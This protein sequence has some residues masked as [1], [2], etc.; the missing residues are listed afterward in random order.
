MM[1]RRLRAYWV[2]P[3]FATSFFLLGLSFVISRARTPYDGARLEPGQQAWLPDGLL[4]N[5]LMVATGGLQS[6]D[7]ITA[8]EGKP[9]VDWAQSLVQFDFPHITPAF[10]QVITYSVLRNGQAIEVQATQTTY[11][12]SALLSQNWGIYIVVFSLQLIM[13]FVLIRRPEE[14]AARALF[15]FAWSMW[16]FPAWTMGLQVTDVLNGWGYWHYRAVTNLL[17]LLTFSALLHTSLVFPRR[18]PI[19]DRYPRIIPVI[20]LAPYGLFTIYMAVARLFSSNLWLWLG[21]WNSGEWAVAMLYLL[22]FFVMTGINY[23]NIHEE[24]TRLKIRWVV[25]GWSITAAGLI[26]LWLLPGAILGQPLI[27]AG[28]ITLLALPL[29]LAL[30]IA[31]LRHRLFDINIVINRTLVYG[32]LTIST[33]ALYI[34]TVG[35]L[36]NLVHLHDRPIIAFLTTGLVAV[37]FQPMHERL[38]LLVNRMMY[39]NRDD[40]Y[41][42]LTRLGQKLEATASVETA[43]PTIVETIAQALKLPYVAIEFKDGNGSRVAAAYGTA[44]PGEAKK[45]PLV[46]QNETFGDLVLAR[47]SERESFT[48]NEERLLADLA[49]EVEVAAHNVRLTADLQRSRQDLVTGREEERRRIRRDLHDEIG[50]L[51]ASQ[52]LTLDAIE[53]LITKDPFAA[54][55]LVRDLKGQTQGAVQE[56]RRIIY[57]LRPPALDDLGLVEALRERFALLGQS[58]LKIVMDAPEDIPSLSAAVETAVYRIAV[59]AVTNVIRHAD[60]RE[61]HVNLRVDDDLQLEIRDDGSGL[62]QKYRPGVGLRAMQERAEE[63]GGEFQLTN[64]KGGGTQI[65]VSLP[66][67]GE[68]M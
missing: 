49:R 6:G 39:G 23:R 59:E 20:Y 19:L 12:F 31:I 66:L 4:V 1:T 56:I 38:Q 53:K 34:F 8:V 52:S 18:H 50:P 60:A 32:S 37:I 46:Y 10:G 7:L 30:A 16:H 5:P 36:G 51:L 55:S 24:A 58:R 15:L 61:C 29:P 64:K 63:L 54:A 62:P 9:M 35:Y 47:R 48:S 11:P 14:P 45:Y 42:I 28:A 26:F 67:A 22:I 65:H 2:F 44:Q 33:M 21:H 68:E 17:F 25:F 27:P 40:P 57:D 41:S 43:L 13:T 3:L